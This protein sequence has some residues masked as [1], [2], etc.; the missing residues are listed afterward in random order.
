MAI[1]TD[2][3]L[4]S[5]TRVSEEGV[6]VAQRDSAL[7]LGLPVL[8][9]GFLNLM[10]DKAVTATE[11]QFLRLVGSTDAHV[12]DFKPF[13][14]AG[15]SRSAEAA[16]YFATHYQSFDEIKSEGLQALIITGA[17]IT[18]PQLTEEPFWNELEYVLRW[19]DAAGVSTLCS[20]LATH[21]AFKV[22][23]GLE[24]RHL[25]NKCW[26]VYEH[27][28][29]RCHP[30]VNGLPAS[31]TMP[32]SRFN[33]VSQQSMESVHV[34]VTLASAIAGVQMA[35]E[36]DLQRIYF[37]GH[38]EYDDISLLKEYKREIVRFALGQREEYPPV[39]E[40][41]FPASSIE[42]AEKFKSRMLAS[43]DR[44][45]LL[46]DFPEDQMAQGLHATWRDVATI[47][48]Q[49]WLSLIGQ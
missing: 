17:N 26:G 32:H 9:V 19:A 33:E 13:A 36:P 35:V 48:F 24:R 42:L 49:N 15:I 5:I 7:L 4:P 8:R 28:V 12:V 38:P 20:C 21:A 11:R 30:I 43:G 22:F 41:Y 14:I 40:N 1:L 44:S 46:S 23:Y 34:Q 2:S 25:G 47:L 31:V 3:S 39:P 10:P 45:D 27:F 6:K 37:Q 29:N 18:Q 16:N